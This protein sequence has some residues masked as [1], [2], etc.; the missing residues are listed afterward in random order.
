MAI[1]PRTGAHPS[2]AEL[3]PEREFTF[4]DLTDKAGTYAT[5]AIGERVGC[6]ELHLTVLRWGP[7]CAR[8]MRQ[9]LE[10]LKELARSRG[11]GRIV[12]HTITPG[13]DVDRRWFKF[14]RTFGF[15]RQR[16]HQTAEL[17]LDRT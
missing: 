14:A 13:L 2:L 16:V 1:T 7:R 3:P 8:A 11:C 15:S 5:A 9:D 17:S 10:W 6:L 12:G 4:V